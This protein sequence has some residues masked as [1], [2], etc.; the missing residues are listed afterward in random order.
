[1]GT[2]QALSEEDQS[3]KISLMQVYLLNCC[4]KRKAPTMV[5]KLDIR[6]AFDSLSW[7]ALQHLLLTRGFPNLFCQWIQN[8]LN[9]G[10]TAILLN[11]IPGPWI[12]CKNGLRQGDPISPYLYIIFSDILQQLIMFAFNNGD[13]QHPIRQD[14]PPATLQYA[15]D[16]IILAKASVHSAIK[17]KTLLQDFALATGL[18]INFQK[19]ALIPMNVEEEIST[20]I[21]AELGTQIYSFPQTYLGLPLSQTSSICL[22]APH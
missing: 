14:L 15:D 3:L 21:A 17:L 13:L 16:T 10:K 20:L 9:T 18:Q 2:K 4:H 5:I 11:G 1:M 12:R 8:I 6:K 7:E 22:S 19:T